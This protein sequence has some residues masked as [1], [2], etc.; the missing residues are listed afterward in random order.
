MI[1]FVLNLFQ[2]DYKC[3]SHRLQI[4]F[5]RMSGGL[6]IC[7][8]QNSDGLSVFFYII[9]NQILINFSHKFGTECKNLFIKKIDII[10]YY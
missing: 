10:N 2:T 8:T 7:F 6:I 1:C 3:V 9:I 5:T 4:I